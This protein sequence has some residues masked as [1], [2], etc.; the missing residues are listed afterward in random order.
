[1]TP[2]TS[3]FVP[4]ET[5]DC[6]R[7][8]RDIDWRRRQVKGLYA[9]QFFLIT[10]EA[11]EAHPPAEQPAFRRRF[12]DFRA[13]FIPV[14]G[15]AGRSWRVRCADGSEVLLETGF[16]AQAE[17]ALLERVLDGAAESDPMADRHAASA[18][19]RAVRLKLREQRIDDFNQRNR[20]D[21]EALRLCHSG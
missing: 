5:T 15:K 2:T 17:Q 14:G 21:F 13:S 4:D 12:N 9:L 20:D 16:L 1:M 8:E 18:L 3:D 10:A 6:E 7:L 19:L 11:G